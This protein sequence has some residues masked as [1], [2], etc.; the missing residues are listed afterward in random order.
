M[1]KRLPLLEDFGSVRTELTKEQSDDLASQPETGMGYHIVDMETVDRM[2]YG[3]TVL[4]CKTAD[5]GI[6]PA[7]IIKMTA[8]KNEE[9]S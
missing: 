7:R 6:D 4:N 2:Q 9:G 5:I 8:R 3:V 1:K